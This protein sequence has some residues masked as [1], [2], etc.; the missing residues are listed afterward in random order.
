M[1]IKDATNRINK[2]NN[3]IEY[4][5]AIKELTE[6]KRIDSDY[7]TNGEYHN[8]YSKIDKDIDDLYE[9]RQYLENFI[10][11][12]LRRNDLY[13]DLL[14]EI[15]YYKEIDTE[16]HTW[17]EIANLVNFSEVYCRKLY[18]K[19]KGKRNV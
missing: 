11:E 14:K 5:L 1:K 15:I 8:T 18:S 7:L 3:Q 9:Q 19:Y 6:L 4:L 13:D 2:I 12:E 10:D 16:K 17:N